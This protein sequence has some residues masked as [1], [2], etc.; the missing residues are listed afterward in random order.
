M[1]TSKAVPG[2]QRVLSGKRSS[3]MIITSSIPMPS[4]AWRKSTRTKSTTSTR[5]PDRHQGKHTKQHKK[6]LIARCCKPWQ[7][8]H[9]RWEPHRRV[10]QCGVCGIRVHQALTVQVLE[11]RL[12]EECPQLSAEE[13]LPPPEKPH[14]PMHKKMTRTQVIKQ[15]LQQQ[16]NQ[17]PP[18]G[19]HE[20]EETAGYLKC[21]RCG[22]NVHK[23]SN[24]QLFQDFIHGR[25]LDQPYQQQHA[26]HTSQSCLVAKGQPSHLHTMW[27][28]SP[29]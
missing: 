2:P 23:R 19:Q 11:E 7:A 25:C 14:Q 24:E 28:H 18:P 16:E 6:Q 20:L 10:H 29:S 26:G 21:S 22:T 5:R 17:R 12:N 9:H 8:P 4:T 1:G 15:I 3:M 27:H 13:H